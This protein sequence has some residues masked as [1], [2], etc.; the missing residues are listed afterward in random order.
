MAFAWSLIY[1]PYFVP[2]L[3]QMNTKTYL[4]DWCLSCILHPKLSAVLP[5]RAFLVSW[6]SPDNKCF[7]EY[8]LG[9]PIV[10]MPPCLWISSS[11]TTPPTTPLL[12]KFEKALCGMVWIF[13]GIAQ[14]MKIT[15]NHACLHSLMQTHLSANQSA[16]HL[17]TDNTHSWFMIRHLSLFTC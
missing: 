11:K 15:C 14:Y 1:D 3:L 9:I 12:F 16:I 4:S 10:S 2:F 17:T 5:V 13:S 8:T 7:K 6:L